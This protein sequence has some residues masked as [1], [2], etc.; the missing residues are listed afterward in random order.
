MSPV[1]LTATVGLTT[2]FPAQGIFSVGDEVIAYTGKTGFTFTGL[3]RGFDGTLAASH[4]VNDICSLRIIAKHLNDAAFVNPNPVPMTI[5][6]VEAGETFPDRMSVQ[7]ML[8]KLL[9]PYQ[10]PSFPSLTLQ[11]ISNPIEVGDTIPAS[12][13]FNWTSVNPANIQPSSIDLIDVTGGNLTLASGLSDD[14]SEA[15]VMPGS[16][17]LVTAGAYQ[18]KI[19]ALDTLSNVIN[20]I[21]TMQWRWRMFYG[22]NANPTLSDVQIQALVNDLLTTTYSRTYAMASGGYK[23]ICFADAAGGQLNTVKDAST[24]LSVPMATVIDDASYSNVDGGGYSYALVS[25]ANPFAVVANYR[26]YRTKNAMGGAISLAV[27]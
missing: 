19:Q 25:V 12:V 10:H 7:E 17:Q 13:T 21:L 24:N 23:Y 18:F 4:A 6:G 14:G 5:G 1:D 22:N 27:T 8:T 9:Y 16:I 2:G 3:T 11:G 26:V 20:T 15:V